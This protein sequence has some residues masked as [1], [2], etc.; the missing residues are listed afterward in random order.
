MPKAVSS[1][2]CTGC[3]SP[4]KSSRHAMVHVGSLEPE[5]PPGC[6]TTKVAPCCHEE[7]WPAVAFI[8]L[9][10]KASA[11][12]RVRVSGHRHYRYKTPEVRRQQTVKDRSSMS[13]EE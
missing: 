11:S 5:T 1:S 3:Q 8:R 7:P 13:G 2:V 6:F 10:R 12:A 4:G 9:T